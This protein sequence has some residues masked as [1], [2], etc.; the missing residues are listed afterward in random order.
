MRKKIII[1]V[2]KRQ[3]KLFEGICA[4]FNVLNCSEQNL[5]FPKINTKILLDSNSFEDKIL[6]FS[7][8]IVLKQRKLI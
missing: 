4:R 7:H 5:K 3:K 1:Q 8:K 6:I 2:K